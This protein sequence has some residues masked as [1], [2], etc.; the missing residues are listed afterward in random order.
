M[1]SGKCDGAPDCSDFSDE[2][3]EECGGTK[4]IIEDK[5]LRFFAW[6]VGSL[7]CIVNIVVIVTSVKGL[8]KVQSKPALV[9]SGCILLISLGDLLMGLY[10][11]SIIAAD[12]LKADNQLTYC[13]EELD[14]LISK[15]CATLGI[16]STVGSQ[17]SLFAMTVLSMYRAYSIRVLFTPRGLPRSFRLGVGVVAGFVIL[18]S[19]G[20]AI[21]PVVEVFDSYFTNG[22]YYK[23]NNLFTGAP[24]KADH[25]R[26]LKNYH[27]RMVQQEGVSWE[28]IKYMVKEMFT[29][30]HA[31]VGK[32]LGFYG[33][34][35]VCLFKYFVTADDGQKGYS[36]GVLALNFTC[37]CIV[38]FCYV[39][40]SSMT[41]N[42]GKACADKVQSK[43]Q[44]RRNKKLQ[45]KISVIVMTDFLC[46][47]PFIVVCILHFG[48]IFDAEPYYAFL[49]IVVLPIN[50]LINPLIYDNTITSGVKRIFSKVMS[51]CTLRS[52]LVEHVTNN[53]DLDDSDV[54]I[55]TNTH[56]IE[57]ADRSQFR[58]KCTYFPSSK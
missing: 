41:A 32:S 9:N 49:S 3:N 52:S 55:V 39:W 37:F 54:E 38:T 19:V 5:P 48:G 12:H 42:S 20:I 13:K 10:L 56:G 21:V 29:S 8:T 36:L 18:L 40:L 50:S 22:L 2:C 35:G 47:V 34:D 11:V 23:N 30:D 15:G 16:L 53:V 58:M 44:N 51:I 4:R 7:A 27:G 17:T 43:R 33:N 1:F 31:G 25:L 28:T 24:S 46:W 26:I 57:L 6:G 45:A 14:W